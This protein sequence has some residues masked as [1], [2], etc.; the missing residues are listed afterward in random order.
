MS[1]HPILELRFAYRKWSWTFANDVWTWAN[2][3]YLPRLCATWLS[4]VNV[5]IWGCFSI[6][7]S[8]CWRPKHTFTVVNPTKKIPLN[9]HEWVQWHY[10]QKPPSLVV[11]RPVVT[12]FSCVFVCNVKNSNIS[13][14]L[15]TPELQHFWVNWVN[16]KEI[17]VTGI[18]YLVYG[19]YHPISSPNGS[20]HTH[21]GTP[22]QNPFYW[23]SM[24]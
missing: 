10:E 23:D 2:Y 20:F 15:L 16:Y 13:Q 7:K 24:K 21:R 17:T 19:E 6:W 8:I 3:L 5:P 11:G 14:P 1:W 9:H 4:L 12:H 22:S 18:I